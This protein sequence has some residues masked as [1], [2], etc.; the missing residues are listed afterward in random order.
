LAALALALLVIALVSVRAYAGRSGAATVRLRAPGQEWVYPLDGERTVS[1]HGPLGET[2]VEIHGGAVRVLSSPCAEKLCVRSGAISRP[3]QW[4]AC[5]PNRVFI[6]V[7][8][9][10]AEGFDALSF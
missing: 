9:G 7:Q 10:S 6:E 2:V 1:L 5:L 8:G 4:L 3:G